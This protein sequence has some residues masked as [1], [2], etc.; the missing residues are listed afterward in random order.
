MTVLGSQ[1]IAD[2][3][4][5][6]RGWIVFG[7]G[8]RIVFRQLRFSRQ[9]HAEENRLC[10]DHN[11]ARV[12]KVKDGDEVVFREFRWSDYFKIAAWVRSLP[13]ALRIA[14][15]FALFGIL[16]SSILGAFLGTVLS[17]LWG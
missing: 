10:I 15:W 1:K 3:F 7:S 5:T 2:Q 12:A 4:S 13:P 17:K 6:E 14:F 16:L 11:F 8:H 9:F